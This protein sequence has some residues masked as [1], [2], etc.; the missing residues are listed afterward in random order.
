[1]E[2]HGSERYALYVISEDAG[3]GRGHVDVARAA[4]AGGAAAVQLRA[5]GLPPRDLLGLAG[6]MAAVCRDAGRLFLVNDRA[7]VALAAGAHGVHLGQDDLPAA[8]ARRIIGSALILGVSAGT[9]AEARRAE[10]DGAD[11]VG[12]GSILATGSKDDAGEPIGFDGLRAIAAAV[13]I[14]VIAIGGLGLDTVG[15]A[16]AAGPV[17]VA[18]MSA[19]TRAPDMVSATRRLAET[20]WQARHLLH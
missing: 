20:V 15:Q 10:A 4:V 7:D 6:E 12:V 9:V 1:M 2:R 17:G 19:V 3:P 11:Y 18:V 13:R 14:P 8:I 16:I 5:K